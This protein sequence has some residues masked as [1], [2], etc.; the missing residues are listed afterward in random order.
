MVNTVLIAPV[1]IYETRV[2]KS[3]LR[4]GAE[5][6]YLIKGKGPYAKATTRLSSSLKSKL[7]KYLMLQENQINDEEIVDF[8]NF[9]EI[10]RTFSKI[11]ELERHENKGVNVIID[12]SSTT[13][14]ATLVCSLLSFLYDI[15]ISFVPPAKKASE[16]V[17]Q[18]RLE[19]DQEDSDEGKEYMIIKMRSGKGLSSDEIRALEKAYSHRGYESMVD[20]IKDMAK[21]DQKNGFDSKYKRHWIRILHA[22][23]DKGLIRIYEMGITKSF[24]LTDAGEGILEGVQKARKKMKKREN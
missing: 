2:W 11:I 7:V 10:Y 14:E 6:I 9:R 23:E 15:N 20:F 1:G 21:E 13:K 12:I 3:I 24:N 5:K 8:T 17:I 19:R 22:L 4:S 18:K 16:S